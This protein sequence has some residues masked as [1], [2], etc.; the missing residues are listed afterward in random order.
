MKWERRCLTIDWDYFFPVVELVPGK[1]LPD[2]WDFYDW[3]HSEHQRIF[4][5]I[6]WPHRAS[7]FLRAGLELPMTSG[8]EQTFWQR[9]DV[10]EAVLYIS[11]SH[12]QMADSLILDAPIAEIV[13][14][15]AHHDGG[16]VGEAIPWKELEKWEQVDCANWTFAHAMRGRKIQVRYPQWRYYAKELEPSVG[17]PSHLA[18][19][20]DDDSHLGKFG[21]VHICRSPAWTPPWLDQAFEEFVKASGVTDQYELE[22]SGPRQFDM[23]DVLAHVKQLNELEA[24]GREE[25]VRDEVH[26][27]GS[28]AQVS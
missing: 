17:I 23:N 24:S 11:D 15:D 4:H 1:G 12:V 27:D 25:H 20:V 10:S 22:Y 19:V 9:V 7:A 14:I 3:G 28:T 13:S 26:R 21:L 18:Q 8:L 2:Y 16:Y 5:E 6:I